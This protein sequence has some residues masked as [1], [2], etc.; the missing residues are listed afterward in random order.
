VAATSA[1]NAWAVG[2]DTSPSGDLVEHWNGRAWKVQPISTKPINPAGGL[3]GVAAT[4]RADAWAVSDNTNQVLH[5]DGRAWKVQAIPP[6][7]Q[8]ERVA[9]TSS[10][11][12]WVVGFHAN[13][14][15]SFSTLVEHWNG[16]AW[17]VQ[18]TPNPGGG[19]NY[20]FLYGVAATSAKNAW[21]VGEYTPGR[22]GPRTLIERWN[23]NG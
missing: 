7:D 1:K 14:H 10:D 17:K 18:P 4:S 9:A 2:G 22:G 8:P 13:R 23:G 15:S 12:A 19:F 21:A 3:G 20:D 11:N 6:R 5:W 16:K